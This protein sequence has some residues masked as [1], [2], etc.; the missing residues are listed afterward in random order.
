MMTT[1]KTI[2]FLLL[3]L[4][5]IA[6]AFFLINNLEYSNQGSASKELNSIGLNSELLEDFTLEK[7][8]FDETE[9][10]TKLLYHRNGE[11]LK[12]SSLG[13]IDKA[14]ADIVLSGQ[15]QTIN[16]LYANAL[17]PY[18]GEISNEIMCPEK[19]MPE[20]YTKQIDSLNYTYFTLFATDRFT[21]GACAEDLVKYKSILAWTYCSK[22]NTFYR[23]EFFIP[24]ETFSKSHLDMITSFRC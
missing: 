12:I 5:I 15:I 9:Q 20:L 17:S 2:G 4:V 7:K 22:K 1:I 6:S 10:S 11:V 16:A 19:F 8:F 21:Y 24:I 14:S 18:P 3:S 23:F 13:S